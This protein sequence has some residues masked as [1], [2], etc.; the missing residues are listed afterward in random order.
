MEVSLQWE[1]LPHLGARLA[2]T[3]QDFRFVR[4]QTGEDDFS[5]NVE[6][7]APPHSLFA[8]L[9]Y[10]APLGLHSAVDFRWVDAY[11]VNDANTVSNWSYRVVDLRFAVDRTWRGVSLVPFFGVDNLFNERYNSSTMLN[12]TGNNYFE[13]APDRGY[14]VGLKLAAAP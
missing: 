11:P 8:G 12:A 2:Y 10:D 13:P 14:Y 9:T 7:G 3:Y 6:P 5:G 4:F 1:P